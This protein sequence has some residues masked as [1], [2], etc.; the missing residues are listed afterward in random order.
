MKAEVETTPVIAQQ[1][2]E[3]YSEFYAEIGS[4]MMDLDIVH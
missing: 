1:E 4:L 2:Y 3:D